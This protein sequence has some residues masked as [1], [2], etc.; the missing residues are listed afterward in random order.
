MTP[1]ERLRVAIAQ[2]PSLTPTGFLTGDG[3]TARERLLRLETAR[4]RFF[5]PVSL[6]QF[7]MARGWLSEARR[8]DRCTTRIEVVADQIE[9]PIG[10]V[11]AA[12]VAEG[13]RVE[14]AGGRIVCNVMVGRMRFARAA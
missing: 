13:Y 10:I 1:I 7:Q 12:L 9:A 2:H 6:I 14:E 5:E 3:L 4:S 8:G 11:I